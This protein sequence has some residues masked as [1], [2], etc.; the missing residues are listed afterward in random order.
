MALVAEVAGTIAGFGSSTILLP[1]SLLVFDFQ[2]ALVLVALMHIF[3]NMSR[4]GF[5]RHGVDTRLLVSFG[6]PSVVGSVAGAL[7]IPHVSQDLLK[8][9]LGVFLV[10]YSVQALWKERL[11]FA[12]NVTNALIGGSLS[13]FM[14][15]LIGTGGPLRAAFLTAYGLK[16]EKYI[17]TAAAIALAV[18]LT[19][20]PVYIQQG[21]LQPHYY[22]YI[23]WLLVIALAG[24]WFGKYIVSRIAQRR[25][26]QIV[27]ASLLLMGIQFVYG[28]LIS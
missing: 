17:A 4:I 10:L 9:L 13:G 19:R 20:I 6:V 25:F 12:P 23:L 1:L 18:D 15:G 5:F 8:G 14:A 16:K 27:L 26:R 24:T 21:F 7:L 22:V 28:W 3:G 2:T 11:R